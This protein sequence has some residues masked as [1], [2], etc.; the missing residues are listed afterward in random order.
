MQVK[1]LVVQ[2]ELKQAL[3]DKSMLKS[4][5]DKALE[6]GME[7]RLAKLVYAEMRAMQQKIDE[8]L[9]KQQS[10]MASKPLLIQATE[11]ERLKDQTSR[12]GRPPTKTHADRLAKA[13]NDVYAI[14]LW[15]ATQSGLHALMPPQIRADPLRRGLH[16]TRRRA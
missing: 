3:R 16:Q 14:E 13:K 12:L 15:V 10:E 9:K 5:C 4:A 7:S 2:E 11:K 1:Q 6:L 8:E